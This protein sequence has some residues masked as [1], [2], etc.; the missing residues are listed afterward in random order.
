MAIGILAPSTRAKAV[1]VEQR[2]S[3]APTERSK[4]PEMRR[5]VM[6]TAMIAV[7]ASPMEIARK[8]ASVKK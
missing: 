6:P 1:R 7:G 2:A 8:L 3:V 4:P 5:M